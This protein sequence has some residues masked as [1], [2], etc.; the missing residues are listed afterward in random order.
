MAS[1][2]LE[3]RE[4]AM[5]TSNTNNNVADPLSAKKERYETAG[6]K[7]QRLIGKSNYLHGTKLILVLASLTVVTFL[8]LLDMSIIATV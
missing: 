8:M 7:D 2:I 1:Q 6:E 5:I 3:G 4:S